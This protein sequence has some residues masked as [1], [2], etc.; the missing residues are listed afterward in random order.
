MSVPSAFTQDGLLPPGDY[1]A[2]LEELRESILVRGPRGVTGEWDVEWRRELVG[3]LEVLAQQLWSV[4]IA[5]I[6]IDGSFAED[7]GHPNDIDGYFDVDF[8]HLVS[9]ELERSLNLLDPHKV[10]TWDPAKR[11]PFAGSPKKQLP[12]WHQYRVE[13]YPHYAPHQKSGIRDIHGNM[14]TFPSAFRQSRR[15]GKPKGIIRLI[16]SK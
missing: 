3:N 5:N 7:K 2:S 14:L 11:T 6:Y 15:D 9:G 10:W 13:L 4:G 12:M 1:D 8:M 16:K